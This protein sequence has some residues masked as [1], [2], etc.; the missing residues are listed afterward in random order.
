MGRRRSYRGTD[1]PWSNSSRTSEAE[2]RSMKLPRDAS[3]ST[4]ALRELDGWYER[5][6]Q[7]IMESESLIPAAKRGRLKELEAEYRERWLYAHDAAVKDLEEWDDIYRSRAESAWQPKMPEDKDT[8]ILK[9]LEL[10][11]LQGRIERNREQPGRLL[12]V[13]EEAVRASNDVIASE[14]ED[15]LPELLPKDARRDF[16]SRARENRLARMSADDRKKL[17]E[18]KAFERE[19]QSTLQGLALQRAMR[20]RGYLP[21]TPTPTTLLT[22]YPAGRPPQ[23]DEVPNPMWRDPALE[24]PVNEPRGGT[25]GPDPGSAA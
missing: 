23:T 14:L 25:I 11:R 22:S 18:H 5:E 2:R 16:E 17:E 20:Q 24:K 10:Q 12:K 19:A 4:E 3:K 21:G 13:Y 7:T 9:A 6:H 8:R 1:S 15:A